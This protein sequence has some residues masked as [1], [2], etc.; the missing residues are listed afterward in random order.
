MSSRLKLIIIFTSIGIVALLIAAIVIMSIQFG[1]VSKELADIK[2]SF[3]SY[4]LDVVKIAEQGLKLQQEFDNEKTK[5]DDLRNRVDNGFSRLSVNIS[6]YSTAQSKL[7]EETAEL[8]RNARQDYFTLRQQLKENE[9]IIY[10]WQRYY[11]DIIAPKN[12]TQSLC[13]DSNNENH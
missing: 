8:N 7:I 5:N 4:K 10:G 9:L 3:N 2:I 1:K 11:C 13:G 6:R 12:G